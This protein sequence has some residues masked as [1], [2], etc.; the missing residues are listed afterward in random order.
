E[1]HEK[2]MS[3]M[4]KDVFPFIGGKSLSDVT[5][6]D[7]LNCARRVVERNAIETAHRMVRECG[8]VFQYAII[9][10][11]C[12]FN[13]AQGLTKGL[14]GYRG[15]SKNFAAF[16]KPD[17]VARLLRIIES[18]SAG[19]VV[20]AGL[21][22]VSLLFVRSKELRMAEWKDIDFEAAEWRYR[23]TKNKNV[24]TLHVVPLSWQALAILRELHPLTGHGRYVFPSGRTPD[25]SRPMSNMAL[26]AA[27]RSAGVTKEETT[28]HGFRAMAQTMLHERLHFDRHIIEIQLTHKE[29][30]GSL[31]TAYDRTEFLDD[32]RRMMQ[33]WADYLDGLRAGSVR[34]AGAVA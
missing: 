23:V 21:K 6:Q 31:G 29:M 24:K 34:P 30:R 14:P 3:R 28:I 17:D 20:R 7:L 4:R 5:P 8:Q 25:G 16:T 10:G 11:R 26:L 22:L 15:L 27:L 13:P 18:I 9:T 2:V 32:R 33:E 1:H 12:S 19:P